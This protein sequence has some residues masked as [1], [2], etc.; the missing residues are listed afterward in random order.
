VR[1]AES[2]TSAAQAAVK[3]AK[4]SQQYL[5]ITAPF[6]GVITK[7]FAH[8]GALVGPGNGSAGGLLELEQV[9]RLRLVID[10]PESEVAGIRRGS[11]VEF[12][13]P[14]YPR[15]KFA[16]TLARVDRSLDPKTRTMPVEL[17]VMNAGNELSPG[18]FPEVSWPA[19]RSGTSLLVPATAVV[20]TTE[21]T[22]VIRVAGDRAEWVNVRKGA[23]IGELVEIFGPVA[24]GD[25][26]VRRANDEIREGTR[27]QVRKSS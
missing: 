19:R 8:P 23:Q 4:L 16:G 13:V 11:R 20:T 7:R 24:R 17:D 25:F 18:M 5:Q 9:S 10:V 15:R 1:A 26:V 22:F 14:A 27:L 12:R 6:D 21:R 3:A 2:A